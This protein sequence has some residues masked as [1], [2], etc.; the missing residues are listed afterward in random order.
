M[1]PFFV[2]QIKNMDTEKPGGYPLDPHRQQIWKSSLQ[3][4]KKS[5]QEKHEDDDQS[6]G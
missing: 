5:L 2:K 1:Y 6:N 4:I 3:R